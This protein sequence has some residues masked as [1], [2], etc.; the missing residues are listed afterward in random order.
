MVTYGGKLLDTSG[1]FHNL[2]RQ[3]IKHELPFPHG[4]KSCRHNRYCAVNHT[5]TII[6]AD[7]A[8]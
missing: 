5:V 8:D 1:F 2:A 6:Y 3:T 7:R 4:L